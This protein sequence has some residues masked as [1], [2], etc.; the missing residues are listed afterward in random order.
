M[1]GRRSCVMV[2][3]ALFSTLGP[4]HDK[5]LRKKFTIAFLPIYSISKAIK[6]TQFLS[7][8]SKETEKPVQ[9]NNNSVEANYLHVKLK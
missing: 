6:K 9:A 7:S 1:A 3:C 8:Q 5:H 4:E 2:S